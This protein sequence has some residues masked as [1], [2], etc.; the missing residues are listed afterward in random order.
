M[1]SHKD[2]WAAID[3]LA[4]E[5]GLSAS[6]LARSAG[7]DATSFN[8]SKRQ[9][10]DGRERWPSTESLARILAASNTSASEFFGYL[11]DQVGEP[12]D[13]LRVPLIGL[14]QAGAGGYFGENGLPQGE[15]WDAVAFP[16]A[17]GDFYAIEVQGD[18]MEPVY[19]DGDRLI[20][21]P[22]AQVRRGD[23]V[24]VRLSNG[25][26]LAK[27]L[28]RQTA[29][30]VDLQSLNPAHADRTVAVNEIDWIARIVWA[31]Q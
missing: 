19:R 23:R 30:A 10:V 3:R 6:G 25:E 12:A 4:S 9:S 17:D 11:A 14:A 28:K 20:V 27:V 5:R 31:S 16:G 22:G 15:G 24:V 26:V 8:P 1:F 29:L 7:L 13:V 21:Q 2:I 18:S